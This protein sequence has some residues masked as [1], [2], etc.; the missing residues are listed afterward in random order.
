[1]PKKVWRNT[2]KFIYKKLAGILYSKKE[3]TNNPKEN[4]N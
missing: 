3:K 1:M 4:S 2:P